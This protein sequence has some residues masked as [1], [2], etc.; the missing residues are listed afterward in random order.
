MIDINAALGMVERPLQVGDWVELLPSGRGMA[1]LDF[2]T[3]PK[4]IIAVA[5]DGFVRFD[6]ING[7]WNCNRFRRV[8]PPRERDE[9]AELREKLATVT[10]H[11]ERQTAEV[12]RLLVAIHNMEHG[13]YSDD[14]GELLKQQLSQVTKERDEYKRRSGSTQAYGVDFGSA[15]GRNYLS[16]CGLVVAVEGDT[17]RDSKLASRFGSQWNKN[18]I[19]YVVEQSKEKEGAA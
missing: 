3:W 2:A 12:S 15:C 8:D 1:Y 13:H 5:N 6:E 7:P 14:V 4:Q 9:V 11:L 17:Q 16:V 19:N 10:Q 18:A